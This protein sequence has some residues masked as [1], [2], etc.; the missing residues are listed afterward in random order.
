VFCLLIGSRCGNQPFG[1]SLQRCDAFWFVFAAVSRPRLV[2]C[3]GVNPFDKSL[4]CCD[5]F[6]L[7]F[8]AVFRR[9]A[10]LC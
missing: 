3:C 2:V 8:A 7:V 4:L 1:W 10:G 6:W 9:L 5:A